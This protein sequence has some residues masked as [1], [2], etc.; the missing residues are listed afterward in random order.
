MI[1]RYILILGRDKV[2][3]H[4]QAEVRIWEAAESDDPWKAAKNHYAA[5]GDRDMILYE[6]KW[7]GELEQIPPP[8]KDSP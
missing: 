6:D 1:K 2:Q 8:K 7:N 5:V 4:K 3:R